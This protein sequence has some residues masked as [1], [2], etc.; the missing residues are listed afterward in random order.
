MKILY[1]Y[2]IFFAQ[3]YGGPSKYFLK[4]ATEVLKSENLKICAPI[5]I[6]EYLK[7]FS[8]EHKY[9]KYINSKYYNNLPFRLKNEIFDKLN[10]KFTDRFIDKFKPD[11]IHETYFQPLK[12]NVPTVLTVYDLIHEK[13]H[14]M[15]KKNVNWRP[16]K[17]AIENADQIICIS[18]NTAEDLEKFYDVSNKKVKVIY[19]GN[20]FENEKFINSSELQMKKKYLLFVGKRDKYKNFNKLLKAYS[21]SKKLQKDFDIV[22]YGS[23]K[24][25]EKEYKDMLNLKIDRSNIIHISGNDEKLKTVYKNAHSFVY[26]SLCEGFGLP[27]LE[28]MSAGCPVVCSNVSS[29]PEIAGDAAKYFNPLST[30]E[31]F[32]AIIETVYSPNKLDLLKSKGTNQIKN[33][34]WEKCSNETINTY[35]TLI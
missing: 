1:N 20:N 8:S 22:C 13:F 3:N 16:K 11:I 10:L 4:L 30:E 35:K 28:A 27:I 23:H 12:R 7:N 33:F 25:T 15:Y 2:H 31:L 9:G 24:F 19:L 26:P 34:S 29:L 14:E 18:K 32:E 21:L 6:N 17:I 5:H